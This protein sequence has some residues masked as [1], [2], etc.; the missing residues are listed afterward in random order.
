MHVRQVQ[1]GFARLGFAVPSYVKY[2]N[3][4]DKN[5]NIQVNITHIRV[6]HHEEPPS[7][8]SAAVWTPSE[9]DLAMIRVAQV[10]RA[11]ENV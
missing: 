1:T 2:Q 9:N 6:W 8:T 7:G 11:K 5:Q 4:K 10:I 3:E